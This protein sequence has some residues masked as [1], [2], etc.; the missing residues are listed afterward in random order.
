MIN[1]YHAQFL[2]IID[3]Y[4]GSLFKLDTVTVFRLFGNTVFF[5]TE[6][7]PAKYRFF[8]FIKSEYLNPFHIA[9]SSV[10]IKAKQSVIVFALVLGLHHVVIHGADP[11][12]TAADRVLWFSSEL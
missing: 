10:V 1:E 12:T 6:Q 3:Q 7:R 8:F 11:V 5:I 2:Y 4:P 9:L